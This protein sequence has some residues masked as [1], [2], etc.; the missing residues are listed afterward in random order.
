RSAVLFSLQFFIIQGAAHP[1]YSNMS[2]RGRPIRRTRQ[3][4]ITPQKQKRDARVRPFLHH[5]RKQK[6][7]YT[8][9]T[10]PKNPAKTGI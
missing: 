7:N 2:A 1:V 3:N 10:P 8:N 4:P 9:G 6:S 5:V